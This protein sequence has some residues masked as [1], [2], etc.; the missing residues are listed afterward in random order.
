MIAGCGHEIGIHNDAL[1]VALQTGRDPADVLHEATDE[2]RV[3]GHTIRSTV[4][5]GN[6]A[7]PRRSVTSTTRCSSGCARPDYGDS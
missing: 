3:Y 6:S 5:H 1:T 4:A 7:L 2:L